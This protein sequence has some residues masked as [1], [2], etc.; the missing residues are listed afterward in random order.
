M[1]SRFRRFPHHI[2]ADLVHGTGLS[3]RG[4]PYNN[5]S[6]GTPYKTRIELEEQLNEALK[7][8][9]QIQR[10]MITFEESLLAPQP[11]MYVPAKPPFGDDQAYAAYLLGEY[12]NV[13][14]DEPKLHGGTKR[15]G[16]KRLRKRQGT[17]RRLRP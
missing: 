1:Y 14:R 9:A 7:S 11:S 8:V 10:E 16:S 6:K 17:R 15:R 5:R 4:N 12:S 2:F 3:P 13:P